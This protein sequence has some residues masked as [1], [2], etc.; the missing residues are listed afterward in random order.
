MLHTSAVS[1]I[2]S[3]NSFEQ[4]VL[5]FGLPILLLLLIMKFSILITINFHKNSI[6]NNKLISKTKT[7]VSQF[8]LWFLAQICLLL[9]PIKELSINISLFDLQSLPVLT[10]ITSLHLAI[11]FSFLSNKHNQTIKIV[12]FT[13]FIAIIIAI[14]F[15]FNLK[16]IKLS[17]A[18]TINLMTLIT[19][20]LFYYMLLFC[21]KKMFAN[22]LLTVF[23]L[24]KK[25]GYIMI[26]KSP[27]P[28]IID[29]QQPVKIYSKV[30]LI[31]LTWKFEKPIVI[32]NNNINTFNNEK[33]LV[34]TYK[35]N[36]TYFLLNKLV[37]TSTK[38]IQDLKTLING[39]KIRQIQ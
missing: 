13:F 22:N 28:T 10:T 7:I 26:I 32:V 20:V 29:D 19:V 27:F 16:M 15:Q 34:I 12:R 35:K 38:T 4:L 25:T 24:I 2:T 8:S 33:L 21:A 37:T 3:I 1:K 17:F 6:N 18:T 31:L 5:F 11:C 30:K 36:L 23:I 39:W 9:L 14:I